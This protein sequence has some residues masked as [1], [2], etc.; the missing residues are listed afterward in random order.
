MSFLSRPPIGATL[1]RALAPP[2]HDRAMPGIPAPPAGDL[3]YWPDAGAPVLVTGSSG[4]LGARVAARLGARR[5]IDLRPG[6]WTSAV[7]S[8]LDRRLLAEATAGIDAVI[9]LA[10]LHAPDVGRASAADF[11]AVN[12]DG[13]AAVLEAARRAGARRFVLASSTSVFG[14]AMARPGTAVHVTEAL[15]PIPRDV[16]DETKLEA[17]RL[18][19]AADGAFP[20]GTAVLRL[21]RC[22]PE[23]PR[24]RVWHR[25]WRG[26]SAADA[27]RALVRATRVSAGGVFVIAARTRLRPED[28][29]DL[30]RDP[31]AVL[32]RRHPALDWAPERWGD[33]AAAGIDRIYDAR[34]AAARLGFVTRH[35][36]ESWHERAE[37]TRRPA[38]P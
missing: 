18:V 37:R 11:H 31:L 12:V 23:P 15:Q 30:A 1:A 24:L 25:F 10:G 14:A 21:A 7:G 28:A 9:H 3:P 5:G 19:L 2:G 29:D 6:P 8:V 22:F 17:E 20:G 36:G 27:A 13:T 32:A 26:L 34:L 4:L 33:L 38:Q 16:Y 35:D